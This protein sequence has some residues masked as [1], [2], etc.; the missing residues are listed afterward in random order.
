MI[1]RPCGSK[2]ESPIEYCAGCGA[3]LLHWEAAD[4]QVR[5]T[6][7]AHATQAVGALFALTEGVD[8]P[9][10]RVDHLYAGTGQLTV[11]I[12]GRGSFDLPTWRFLLAAADGSEAVSVT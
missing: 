8:G 9:Q 5:A 2:S 11:A 12:V 4:G 7:S 10:L 3:K 1:C 6:P